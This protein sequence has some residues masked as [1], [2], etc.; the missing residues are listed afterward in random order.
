MKHFLLVI[1]FENRPEFSSFWA[2]DLEHA[3]EQLD[4]EG[5]EYNA[6][7]YV[8]HTFESETEI[9]NSMSLRK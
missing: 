6:R 7:Q 5:F 8:T 3:L 9:Q 1:N 2:D 4:D